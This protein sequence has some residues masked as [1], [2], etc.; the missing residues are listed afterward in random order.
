M[1]SRD[2]AF[3]ERL[4]R[5]KLRLKEI[6]ERPGVYL[7][8]NEAGEVIYV[9]K[10]RDLRS[11]VTS[12]LAGRGVRDLKT[13][14]LVAEIH[15]IDFVETNNE[16]EA[17]LL[18]NN[19]IKT[20]QPRY[21]ILLR[22][23]K[24][25]PYIKVTMS[26]A[27][28]RVVFTRRVDRK[29]GDLYFGPFF[30]GTARRI[31]KL[32]GDQFRLRSCDLDIREGKSALPRPCLYYDMHQCLAPCVVG[33]TTSAAYREMVDDVVLFLSG[34]RREL[35]DRLKERM[36]RAAESE[37]FELASYY[38]D[39]VRTTERIQAEQQVASA[40]ADETDVFGLHEEGGD[41]AV[42]IFVL[43]EGNLV[44][45][46]ELFWEKIARVSPRD[47]SLGSRAAVLPGQPLH[48]RGGPPAVS[49]RGWGAH[50]GVALG[51]ARAAG[52]DPRAPAGEGRG[53]DR[54]RE[55][56]RAPGARVPFPQVDAGPAPDR[57]GAP[58]R[59][60]G[61][62]AR[63]DAHDRVVR[64][65]EFPGH[66]LGRG[67]GR[68]RIT[69]VSTRAKYR[70]FNIR[71]VE[72]ADDFRSMAE[73]VERRYRRA[74]EEGR[75]VPDLILIDGGRGQLNAALSALSKL[76]IEDVAVAG[77]AKQEEEIYLPGLDEPI[78][79]ERNDPALHLLQMIRDE[80]HRF[81]VSSHRRRRARR[82]LTSELD[83]LEGIGAKRRRLL[84]EHFGSLSA[85]RQA[86]EYDLA[87]VL[88]PKVG[89][90]VYEQL[91]AAS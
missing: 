9:G 48:P 59:G 88:G 90:A 28:P 61:V 6:P 62:R 16:L 83:Q 82:T 71:S 13:V 87:K 91:H 74:G 35:L 55:P 26:E 11:R 81:A 58:G 1:S 41:V 4:K 30:A 22:D 77:L 23:D 20:H 7:H 14:A 27:Y 85:V 72:G 54:A 68:V 25:Y 15:A 65:L 70:V 49:R 32:I 67:D 10:A 38:R 34:K 47:V 33:L 5:L 57:R 2:R 46:R 24:S 8:R 60:R 37:Q 21:N 69:A 12:Y 76:G 73:A 52:G 36:Y 89:K 45:R 29:K 50:R 75:E 56:Q 44:D 40:S 64:H 78:R 84:L 79:L 31:L 43:R 53:P 80:T 17:I 86:S 3:D 18:E 19:L 51:A 66:G 63:R 39:L 42:Q